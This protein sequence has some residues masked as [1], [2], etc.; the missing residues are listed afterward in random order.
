MSR[1][2]LIIIG[3]V[4]LVL[5]IGFGIYWILFKPILPAQP[6]LQPIAITPSENIG[7]QPA[8]PG[9]RPPIAVQPSPAAPTEAITQVG[10]IA[11]GGLTKVTTMTTGATLNPRVSPTG[12]AITYFDP[13]SGKFVRIK[14]DGSTETLSDKTFYNVSKITWAPRNEKAVLQYPDGSKILYNFETKQQVSLPSHWDQFSF[15]PNNDQ[16]AFLS[17]GADEENQWLAI[18]RDD[19]SKTQAIE[20][21]GLNAYK[22][23]VAWSPNEQIIAFSNTPQTP[24]GSGNQEILLVGKNHENFK[25]LKVNGINFQGE[26]SPDGTKI[27]YNATRADDDWK[28]RIWVTA[29]TPDTI[30]QNKKPIEIATWVD[31]C[32][33][34][35]NEALYCAVPKELPRGAGLLR[36]VANTIADD[37]YKIDL[38]T[39]GSTLI[40]VPDGDRTM[41]QVMVTPDGKSLYFVNALTQQLEKINLR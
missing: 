41:G 34:A 15:A 35:S 4:L 37:L 30:G 7:L 1:R 18:A 8:Q 23:Q 6:V 16:I 2:I 22:V 25:S 31:K 28:P 20:P 21:L 29:G 14:N 32:G 13:T 40:A 33:F 10:Q 39:G 17:L 9:E 11:N 12:N 26:W 27:L 36:E 19:G 24:S 38:K 5:L 3:F